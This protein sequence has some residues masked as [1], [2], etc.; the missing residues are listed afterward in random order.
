MRRLPS[1]ALCPND[2][3]FWATAMLRH[4]T[5]RGF[6][7]SG[8]RELLLTYVGYMTASIVAASRSV[9]YL[10]QCRPHM[11][12]D[13]PD[14]SELLFGFAAVSNS[15]FFR[16]TSCDALARPGMAPSSMCFSSHSS[17]PAWESSR[18]SLDAR[19]R[20]WIFF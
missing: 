10:I 19:I 3:Q 17:A 14:A 9:V 18:T 15:A 8:S 5:P 13:L 16:N 20:G 7:I 6:F 1:V 11:R 12:V 4:K 2:L